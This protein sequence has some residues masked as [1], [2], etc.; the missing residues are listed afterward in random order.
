[1]RKL[2]SAHKTGLRTLLLLVPLVGAVQLGCPALTQVVV[3]VGL[4]VG[5]GAIV[6]VSA[7]VG[8]GDGEAHDDGGGKVV[9]VV[10]WMNCCC[11]MNLSLEE[12][13]GVIILQVM[14]NAWLVE[15]F[16]NETPL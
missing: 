14:M 10:M 1:M 7:C 13:E 15:L 2:C 6:F 8:G 16:E 12:G 5:D 3:E 9:I 4:A 11:M